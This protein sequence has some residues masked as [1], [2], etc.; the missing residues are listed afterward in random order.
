[1]PNIKELAS[2]TELGVREGARIDPTAFPGVSAN[3]GFVWATTPYMSDT[4]AAWVVNF[5]SGVVDGYMRT[6]TLGVRLLRANDST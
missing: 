2:L 6:G 4:L 5:S 1:M 3:V